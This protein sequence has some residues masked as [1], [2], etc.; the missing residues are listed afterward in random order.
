MATLKNRLTT[1]FS[2]AFER[3]G[4]EARFGGVAF[5]DRPDLADFQCNGALAAAKSKGLK[6]RELAERIAPQVRAGLDSEFGAGSV[7]LSIAGPG[8]I[9]LKLS[10]TALAETAGRLMGDVRCGVEPRTRSRKVIV[11]F[12]G[13]NVAK[14]MHVG[15]LRSSILGDALVR[16]H[17]FLGDTVVGDN[18]LGDWGTPMGM[19]ICE[20]R[21]RQPTLPYFKAD[22]QGQYPRESPVAMEELEQLYPVAAKRF[23]EDEAFAKD[24][25]VATDQLQQGRNPGYRALWQHFCD[26]TIAGL[27]RDFGRLGIEF[28]TWYGESFY[29]SKMPAMVESL[30]QSGLAKESEGALVVPLATEKDPDAPP[31]ILVKSGGGYLYHTSDLATIQHRVGVL[32]ADLILYAVDKRQSLHF[33][34]V[35][36]VAK[37]AKLAGEAQLVHAAF[38]TM[39]GKDGKPFKTREGGVLKLKELIEMIHAEAGKRLAEMSVERAYSESEKEDIADKV[40]IATLKYADLKN[41]R[42][43]DYVFDLERFSQFEGNTGPYLLYAVVRIQSILKK[44]ADLGMLPSA[45]LVAPGVDSERRLML[46]LLRLPEALG[47]AYVASEPHHLADFG[48]GLAQVY[49]SFYKDCHILTEPDVARRSGWL[50]LCLLTR[51]QIRLCM[52]LLGIQVPERM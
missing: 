9:N 49:N 27:K 29:E 50:Q 15:H 41:N 43:V 8:F 17:R 33:K 40:G 1:V 21:R 12:G 51:D 28:D 16:L 23:K 44:A 38:G 20:I 25:L 26:T 31:L 32:K 5:A 39:N 19:L 45:Q 13:P 6:P 18:H 11:D 34:Q 30:R 3:E 46:E 22:F 48:F 35:F 24:V 4:F 36:Q 10:G 7:D 42:T 37:R 52:N 14:S 2:K 47:R